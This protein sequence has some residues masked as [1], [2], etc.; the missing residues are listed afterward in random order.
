M[1][2]FEGGEN[3]N[4]D[5]EEISVAIRKLVYSKRSPVLIFYGLWQ[6]AVALLKELCLVTEGCGLNA[7][8]CHCI[9]TPACLSL[10]HASDSFTEK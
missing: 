5:R 7:N 4:S 6:G 8:P 9:A 1:F 3:K 2:S 10:F